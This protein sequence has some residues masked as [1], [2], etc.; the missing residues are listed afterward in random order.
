MTWDGKIATVSG[1]S[2]WISGERSRA[3]VQKLRRRVDAI[4]AGTGTVL[5]D[6]PVLLPRP[7]RGRLP[8]RIILDRRGHLPLNL[9][10]FAPGAGPRLYVTGAAASRKSR[11]SRSRRLRRIAALGIEL[12]ALKER[13]GKLALPDLLNHMGRRGI[14]QLLVEGGG[15]LHGDFI[16]QRL[17]QEVAVFIAPKLLGGAKAPG[18]VGGGGIERL[19]GALCLDRVKMQKSGPDLFLS[20]RV[21]S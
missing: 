15:K 14:S 10:L 17:A 1:D 6:N 9:K 12:L 19:S 16:D 20:A 18:P 8:L 7:P 13:R 2:R 5:T 4:L 21:K 3:I 11:T